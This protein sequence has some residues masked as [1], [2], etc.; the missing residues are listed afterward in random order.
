MGKKELLF[1]EIEEMPDLLVG[2]ILEFVR[3]LKTRSM[4]EKLDISIASESSLTKDWLRAEEDD[5]WR[6]L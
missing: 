3:S 5:A 1:N 4:G 2:E 6:D